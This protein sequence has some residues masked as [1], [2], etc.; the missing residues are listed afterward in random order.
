MQRA[1]DLGGVGEFV[2]LKLR[3]QRHED[4]ALAHGHVHRAE[5]EERVS[6]GQH[7]LA[8]V[9]GHGAQAGNAHI[10][11][12]QHARDRIAGMQGTLPAGRGLGRVGSAGRA[13]LRHRDAQLLE[14][15]TEIAQHILVETGEHQR[16]FDGNHHLRL[17]RQV[18]QSARGYGLRQQIARHRDLA[19][20]HGFIGR[21]RVGGP[22]L[23]EIVDLQ[24]QLGRRDAADRVRRKD[25]EPQGHRA[26]Q[27][28]IDVDGAAAHTTGDIGAHGFAAQLR[29]DDVLP[30]SPLVLPQAEDLYGNRLRRGPGKYRPRGAPHA[31][32]E[33]RSLEDLHLAD[34]GGRR[35]V[36]RAQGKS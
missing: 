2:G 26:H 1:D 4:F 3:S 19:A 25:A 35:E 32:T 23:V 34:R 22:R 29:Q 9:I 14:Q 16:R 8:I 11:R 18:G 10:A 28:A 13:A 24:H 21:A 36:C 31:R 5:I 15:R 33:I 27:L 17:P 30:R 7:V 12:N 6:E 20:C